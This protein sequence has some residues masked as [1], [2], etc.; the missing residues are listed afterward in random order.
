MVP[1]VIVQAR[2]RVGA[3][4][5]RVADKGAHVVSTNRE[6]WDATWAGVARRKEMGLGRN[7]S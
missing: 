1:R 4:C 7:C 5:A 3:C 6:R 2:W